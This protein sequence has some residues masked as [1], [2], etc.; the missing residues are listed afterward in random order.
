MIHLIYNLI[1]N[2]IFSFNLFGLLFACIG[3]ACTFLFFFSFNGTFKKE[4]D[5][6]HRIKV[7]VIFALGALLL[8]LG[9]YLL[10]KIG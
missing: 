2:K 5:K 10:I 3:L 4:N 8:D 1:F 6:R 7:R 9:I